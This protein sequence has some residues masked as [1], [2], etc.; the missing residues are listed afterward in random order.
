MGSCSKPRR[1]AATGSPA[2][3]TAPSPATSSSAT[4]STSRCTRPCRWPSSRPSSS[5]HAT[6][7]LMTESVFYNLA[8]SEG[9][10]AVSRLRE[11]GHTRRTARRLPERRARRPL[12]ARRLVAQPGA[13]S[14][15]PTRSRTR[16]TRTA[17]ATSRRRPT[18]RTRTSAGGPGARTR[19]CVRARSAWLQVL[20]HPAIWVYPGSTM[21]QTM[22]AML[23]A[24]KERRLSQLALDGIDL[25]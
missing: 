16:S 14:T 17:S 2:S 24:E 20:V 6:Y 12:R 18:A 15:C 25:D 13:R 4:T 19:S 1:P 8:S 7:L 21:G 9:V 5:V 23:D 10:E 3:A 11:L 22:R